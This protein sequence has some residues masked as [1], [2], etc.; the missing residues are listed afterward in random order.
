M[1][2]YQ[3][4]YPYYFSIV[5]DYINIDFDNSGCE[6][7][8]R[9]TFMIGEEINSMLFS[10]INDGIKNGAFR[11]QSDVKSVIM[12]I[13]GMLSGFIQLASNK[14]QYILQEMNLSKKDFLEKGFHFLYGAIEN[15]SADK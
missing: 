9:E 8:E 2:S 12:T 7:S 4:K 15:S 11:K 5:L 14:E 1:V 10:F 6:E 3:E 13:W